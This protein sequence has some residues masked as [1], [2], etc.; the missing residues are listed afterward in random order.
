MR[1][2]LWHGQ[3]H[4]FQIVENAFKSRKK[5]IG[6]NAFKNPFK[7]DEFKTRSKRVRYTDKT[8]LKRLKNEFKTRSKRVENVQK[9]SSKRVRNVFNTRAKRVEDG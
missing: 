4:G 1:I 6:I 3:Q 2:L 9:T 5:R 8:R 7:Q